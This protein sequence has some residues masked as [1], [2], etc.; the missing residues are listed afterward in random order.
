ML[1]VRSKLLRICRP[2]VIDKREPTLYGVI[3]AQD[4]KMWYNG[5]MIEWKNY[6]Q[7]W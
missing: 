3:V 1:I 7:E 6:G 2:R 4:V 5:I